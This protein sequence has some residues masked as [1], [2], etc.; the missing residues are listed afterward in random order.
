MDLKNIS[1][2]L[3]KSDDVHI[4]FA[5]QRDKELGIP[6]YG[7]KAREEVLRLLRAGI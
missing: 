3:I 2:I 6:Y 1:M 7:N 4:I 5:S